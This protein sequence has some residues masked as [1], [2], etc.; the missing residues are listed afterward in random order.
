MIKHD[1]HHGMLFVSDLK[2]IL[3]VQ[4]TLIKNLLHL[5]FGGGLTFGDRR[6]KEKKMD[7]SPMVHAETPVRTQVG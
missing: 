6:T 4:Q 5:D 1:F 7:R 3:N 2:M